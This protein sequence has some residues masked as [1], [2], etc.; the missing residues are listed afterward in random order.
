MALGSSYDNLCPIFDFK[1]GGGV[2]FPYFPMDLGQTN[3]TYINLDGSASAIHARVRLPIAGRLITC[4]AL[5]VSDDQGVKTAVATAEPVIGINVG[6][7]PLASI[8]AGTE[9]S[10]I[11]CNGSGPVG[12]RWAGSTTA[13][14]VTTAQE[15]IVH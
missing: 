12:K 13:T 7:Y 10:T 15:L 8:D 1:N 11:T 9:I 14:D 2:L 6:T 3:L 4:E 5:A